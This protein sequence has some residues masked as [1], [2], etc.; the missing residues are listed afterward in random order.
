MQR[1]RI[2]IMHAHT[3]ISLW[4]RRPNEHYSHPSHSTQLQQSS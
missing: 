1:K 3:S 4:Q 2:I